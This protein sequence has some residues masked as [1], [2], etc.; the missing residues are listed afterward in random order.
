VKVALKNQRQGGEHS[1]E[2]NS[3]NHDEKKS[4]NT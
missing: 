4:L 2:K 3:E 1:A